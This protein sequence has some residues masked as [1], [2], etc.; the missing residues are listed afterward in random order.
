MRTIE[1]SSAFRKDLRRIRA[2]PRYR[3][4]VDDLLDIVT[5]LLQR[6]QPLPAKFKDHALE[7]DWKERRECH[8]KP[9]LLLIY[10]QTSDGS[11][12]RLGRIGSHSELFG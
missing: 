5:D 4:E 8:L 6:D 7:G 2:N 1:E 9:D 11:E 12:L 10:R 3:E